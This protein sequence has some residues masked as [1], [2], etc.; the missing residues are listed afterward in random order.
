MP[1]APSQMQRNAELWLQQERKLAELMAAQH[2]PP[3]G[4]QPLSAKRERE[5]WHQR[6]EQRDEDALWEAAQTE[7]AQWAAQNPGVDDAAMHANWAEQMTKVRDLVYPNRAKLLKAGGRAM[8]IAERVKYAER[9]ARQGAEDGSGDEEVP[10][11]GLTELT[12]EDRSGD[13]L[14]LGTRSD[15]PHMGRIPVDPLGLT[16]PA[17][18]DPYV[19]V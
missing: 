12:S 4:G 7:H 3:P 16:P 6:D 14:D 9:M 1:S 17:E 2:T 11:G 18:E 10:V 19:D 15:R 5:L 13:F 8:S